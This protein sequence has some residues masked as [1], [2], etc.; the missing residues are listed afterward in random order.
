MSLKENWIGN[1]Q[2]NSLKSQ[3]PNPKSWQWGRTPRLSDPRLPVLGV[4]A[5]YIVL[6]VT[7]LRFNRSPFQLLLIISGAYLL[8]RLLLHNR[9]VEDCRGTP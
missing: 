8:D 3:F 6:G 2:I 4:L 7:V 9:L 5:L 1:W